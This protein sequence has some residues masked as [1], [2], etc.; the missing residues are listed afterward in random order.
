MYIIIIMIIGQVKMS[1]SLVL[2]C[3]TMVSFYNN[4]NV[5]NKRNI[6]YKKIEQLT[7]AHLVDDVS[8]CVTSHL[9]SGEPWTLKEHQNV[10]VLVSQTYHH[11]H[12][13]EDRNPQIAL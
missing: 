6:L 5:K 4:N 9:P 1:S 12:E 2:T 3:A 13:S 7:H 8:R 10:S 11:A